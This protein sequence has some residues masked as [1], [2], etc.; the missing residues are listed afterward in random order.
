MGCIGH[1]REAGIPGAIADTLKATGVR[2]V[3]SEA[4]A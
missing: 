2:R 4:A 3:S 1:F